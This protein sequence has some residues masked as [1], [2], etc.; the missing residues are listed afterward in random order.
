[1]PHPFADL[2]RRAFARAYSEA[3]E[4]ID[5]DLLVAVPPSW[6]VGLSLNR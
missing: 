1:M 4:L 5:R 6:W 2:Q 3:E